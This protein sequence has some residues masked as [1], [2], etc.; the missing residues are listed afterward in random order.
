MTYRN[1]SNG[2]LENQ[3]ITDDMTTLPTMVIREPYFL[4]FKGKNG[5]LAP[6]TNYKLEFHHLTDLI[7]ETISMYASALKAGI[8]RYPAPGE[9]TSE[10][11]VHYTDVIL[12]QCWAYIQRTGL[13]H[14]QHMYNAVWDGIK[15]CAEQYA[16]EEQR[17]IVLPIESI[18]MP[19]VLSLPLPA[20]LSL[21]SPPI[22][23]VLLINS[24][25]DIVCDVD[26]TILYINSLD[27]MDGTETEI[28][29]QFR[30]ILEVLPLREVVIDSNMTNYDE[31]FQSHKLDYNNPYFWNNTN[32]LVS[33]NNRILTR[34]QMSICL[35]RGNVSMNPGP[36]FDH[37]TMTYTL[38]VL[39]D[40]KVKLVC[41]GSSSEYDG[42]CVLTRDILL[43]SLKKYSYPMIVPDL[44]SVRLEFQVVPSTAPR[45]LS[46]ECVVNDIKFSSPI[47]K[48]NN[49]SVSM[50]AKVKMHDTVAIH[51][52]TP[53]T[54]VF[55]Y[56]FISKNWDPTAMLSRQPTVRGSRGRRVGREHLSGIKVTMSI[57]P[58][59]GK[60]GEQYKRKQVS[61][62]MR[63]VANQYH[64]DQL[65]KKDIN[66]RPRKQGNVS[67]PKV[68]VVNK[69]TQSK[70]K[71]ENIPS[72]SSLPKVSP[73]MVKRKRVRRRKPKVVIA[74][75]E[76]AIVM[77]PTS[78]GA[79]KVEDENSPLNAPVVK[80]KRKR[81]R[82]R[83]A[84]VT[85]PIVS[86]IPVPVK[87]ALAEFNWAD[88][89]KELTSEDYL[90][91]IEALGPKKDIFK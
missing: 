48:T 12:P 20:T 78:N 88:D 60:Q 87:Q 75:P 83:P 56:S 27:S 74:N 72:F 66:I 70:Q 67:P 36:H 31:N 30:D 38:I 65:Q 19:E 43:S 9:L 29:N 16:L 61:T 49:I 42:S 53:V 8:L 57:P 11:Y 5:R 71:F 76:S 73:T 80:P 62:S 91:L 26:K 41:R 85:S 64:D 2:M 33:L 58:Q 18:Q 25:T 77:V 68:K 21:E 10:Q 47:V 39:P 89:P 28:L 84:K 1:V 59:K 50:Y 37:P 86:T 6:T 7:F 46:L 35:L 55:T 23:Y 82:K 17:N 40:N 44:I 79:N 13:D 34:E 45:P 90:T 69:P 81:K 4:I 15:Y 63:D 3:L 24:V 54:I 52:N 22:V 51:F 14:N 32:S